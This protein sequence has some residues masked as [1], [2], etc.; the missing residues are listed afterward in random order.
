MTI[1]SDTEA[2]TADIG[3]RPN[4]LPSMTALVGGRPEAVVNAIV[5]KRTGNS[6]Y[7]ENDRG[8]TEFAYSNLS[9]T[10]ALDMA[11]AEDGLVCWVETRDAAS[12]AMNFGSS[13]QLPKVKAVEAY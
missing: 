6:A 4:N 3:W 8:D 7:C 5:R 1:D 12:H 13:F 11:R 10:R 2:N 9:L